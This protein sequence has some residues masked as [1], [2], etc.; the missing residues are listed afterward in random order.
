MA[1]KKKAHI[2]KGKEKMMDKK[3]GMKMPM[4]KGCK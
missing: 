4:K 1:H 3:D 2:K